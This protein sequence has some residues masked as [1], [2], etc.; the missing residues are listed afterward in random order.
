MGVK[1]QLQLIMAKADI[2][3]QKDLIERLAEI[4]I[5]ARPLTI[6]NIFN[7]KIKQL[8]VELI[9]GISVVTNSKPGDWITIE[10]DKKSDDAVGD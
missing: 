9:Y 2:K 8:P 10:H 6:S 5:T 4:G 1:F 3:K 7:N